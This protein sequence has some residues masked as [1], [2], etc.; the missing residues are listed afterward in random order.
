MA[1]AYAKAILNEIR[2]RQTLAVDHPG[3]ATDVTDARSPDHP[4]HAAEMGGP[5]S[6]FNGPISGR[7]VVAGTTSTGPVN[8]NFS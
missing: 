3:R 5:R 1:A 2:P 8:M 6:V 4:R 7:N